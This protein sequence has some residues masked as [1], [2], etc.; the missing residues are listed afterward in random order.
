MKVVQRFDDDYL[1][2][3]RNA[4]PE[5]VLNFLEGFRLMQATSSPSK[6]ISLKVPHALLDG[7]RHRCVLEG[8]PYQT[9]IKRL[10]EEWLRR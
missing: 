4:D 1:E 6:L 9:Q 7:F 5:S 2:R 3:C 10:M 8:V